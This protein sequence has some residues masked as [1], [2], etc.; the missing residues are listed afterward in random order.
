MEK[1]TFEKKMIDLLSKTYRPT[2]DRTNC[3][4][5][6]VSQKRPKSDP[7]PRNKRPSDQAPPPRSDKY[8]FDTL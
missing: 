7:F 8:P 2:I 4:Q 3:E 6:P 1:M 5:T